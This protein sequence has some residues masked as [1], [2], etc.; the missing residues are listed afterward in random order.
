MKRAFDLLVADCDADPDCRTAYG[1]AGRTLAATRG[2]AS[3]TRADLAVGP[4]GDAIAIWQQF[5]GGRPDDGSRSNIAINR[6]DRATGIWGSAMFAETEPGNAIS[7]R[8]SAASGQ[9]ATPPATWSDLLV[10]CDAIQ[11]AG[12]VPIG[13]GL[14]NSAHIQLTTYAL[15]ATA[16]YARE[17]D[18]DQ[19]MAAGGTSFSESAGWHETFE[20]FLELRDGGFR[21]HSAI[22]KSGDV[23]VDN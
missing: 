19:R 12:K 7:P 20:K 5:E 3:Y 22:R 15:A 9:A 23:L 10:V 2:D 1:D 4:G 17:P 13:L 14:A 6:F 18:F 21:S 11:D 16:V 8:V